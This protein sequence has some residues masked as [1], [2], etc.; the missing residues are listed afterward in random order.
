MKTQ[1]KHFKCAQ[2]DMSINYLK[3]QVNS[4]YKLDAGQLQKI[5]R[6]ENMRKIQE[7]SYNFDEG[8]LDLLKSESLRS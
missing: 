3:N 2:I 6:D 4:V 1:K 7:L 5:K 8:Q